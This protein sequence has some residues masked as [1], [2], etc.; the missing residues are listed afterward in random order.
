[1]NALKIQVKNGRLFFDEPTELPEGTIVE[2]NPKTVE[3]PKQLLWEEIKVL[4]PNEWV[5]LVNLLHNDEREPNESR[6]VIGGCL[7]S[8]PEPKRTLAQNQAGALGD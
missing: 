3:P 8:L 6:Q 7:C 5:V 2:L 4:Y 1:M